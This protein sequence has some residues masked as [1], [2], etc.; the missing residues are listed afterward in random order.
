MT[1]HRLNLVL[2]LALGACIPSASATSS[3]SGDDSFGSTTTCPAQGCGSNTPLL[4]GSRFLE[5]LNLDGVPNAD[6]VRYVKGSFR[7][8]NPARSGL[9]L[10]IR[11]GTIVG[12]DAA[13]APVCTNVVHAT[14]QI[15]VAKE[16]PIAISIGETAQV[17]TWLID[18]ALRELVPSYE[19]TWPDAHGHPT[20]MCPLRTATWMDPEQHG[21][22]KGD[23]NPGTG[24]QEWHAVTDH[25]LIVQGETYTDAANADAARSGPRWINFACAGAAFSK[26]RLLGYD[27]MPTARMLSTP[28][29]REA[30]LKMITARYRGATS[31]TRQGMPLAWRSIA[32][33]QYYGG[34]D[35][36]TLGPI[37]A[38]WDH[39]GAT[40]L[41]HAR[42]LRKTAPSASARGK[43]ER[44]RLKDIV[45]TRCTRLESA[46]AAA[47][48][49]GNASFPQGTV[50]ATVTVDHVPHPPMPGFPRTDRS[51]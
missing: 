27:P 43:N 32:G 3:S 8:A 19:M 30:T 1:L 29:Q 42:V 14:F 12:V 7:C 41:S 22:L 49:A 47:I 21:G 33:T 16:R 37:E 6:D 5:S 38:L 2:L 9:D 31:H 23:R 39:T 45:T 25:L 48:M 17:S 11:S 20:S 36:A 13:N 50:W 15:A 51:P 28:G 40:C 34:P 24:G 26:M 35:P 4:S 44:A 46:T 18:G 10:D